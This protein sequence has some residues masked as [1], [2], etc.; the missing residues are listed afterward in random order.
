LS[1]NHKKQHFIRL[2][3]KLIT[4]K[5]GKENSNGD[6]HKRKHLKGKQ[7][8]GKQTPRK[9]GEQQGALL[10]YPN[11]ESSTGPPK[12]SGGAWVKNRIAQGFT[13]GKSRKDGNPSPARPRSQ[14]EGHRW[15]KKPKR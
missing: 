11:W 2:K 1:G 14:M 8:R 13:E 15:D 12:E 3:K 10:I 7:Q 5:G 6:P 4:N 9:W